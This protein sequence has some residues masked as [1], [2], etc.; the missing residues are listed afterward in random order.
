MRP[1]YTMREIIG[2]IVSSLALLLK[3]SA[4]VRERKMCKEL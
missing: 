4:D 1:N 3:G 2:L